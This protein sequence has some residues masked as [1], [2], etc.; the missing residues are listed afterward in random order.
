M[1]LETIFGLNAAGNS[2]VDNITENIDRIIEKAGETI[3]GILT[4]ITQ[5]I[6]R[7]L[8]KLNTVFKDVMK[9]TLE[10]L[11]QFTN[12]LF[13]QL[14]Q[15]FNNIAKHIDNILDG[16]IENIESLL[17]TAKNTLIEVVT[18]LEKS[19]SNII[20]KAGET[21]NY[22]VDKVM[23]NIL[24][25]SGWM[26]LGIG[27]IIFAVMFTKRGLP[28]GATGI[29]V[30]SII[31]LFFI[32]F[33][34]IAIIPHFRTW[35]MQYTGLGLKA[36]LKMAEE[37]AEIE[38]ITPTFIH[39]G[40]TKELTIRGLFLTQKGEAPTVT[41]HNLPV[42]IIPPSSPG[43]LKLNLKGLQ[44]PEGSLSLRLIYSEEESKEVAIESKIPPP[45]KAPADLFIKNVIFS[46]KY[47]LVGQQTKVSVV[48]QNGG[49]TTAT[50]FN[51][52][53]TAYKGATPSKERA[54]L[55]PGK[56]QSLQFH[57]TWNNPGNQDI[58]IHADSSQKI[59]EKTESNN[60]KWHT[61]TV[62]PK[63]YEA[64]IDFTRII[65]PGGLQTTHQEFY[66]Q[67]GTKEET[68]KL[69]IHGN[70]PT[71]SVIVY[72]GDKLNFRGRIRY[73]DP[74]VPA[75]YRWN[76]FQMLKTFLPNLPKENPGMLGNMHFHNYVMT[77]HYVDRRDWYGNIATYQVFY[78]I[79]FK[80]IG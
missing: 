50:D 33:A 72:P 36:R 79:K 3:R 43:E 7:I 75:S 8:S 25:I 10:S 55:A 30:I 65:L 51:I 41:L 44:L 20:I 4:E 13:Y 5:N 31:G 40:K 69:N 21:V 54:T 71:K 78:K 12:S 77:E 76:D 28:T 60:V 17:E 73:G 58:R 62:Y 66:I 29:A 37:E 59:K 16:I 49:K 9:T 23:Y 47:P 52:S 64:R 45:P 70:A 22:V 1:I 56:R 14:N 35:V 34:S 32:L 27:L 74:N 6:E 46:P 15:S 24:T 67:A 42:S 18:Q 53:L 26:L 2:L 11:E 48:V 19:I 61:I 80:G 68:V 63:K 39:P 38:S 57:C